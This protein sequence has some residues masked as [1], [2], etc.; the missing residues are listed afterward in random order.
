MH[1]FDGDVAILH[2]GDILESGSEY[3]YGGMTRKIVFNDLNELALLF[4]RKA[5]RK[6]ILTERS[7]EG[8]VLEKSGVLEN[9]IK[10]LAT[11]NYVECQ[12]GERVPGQNRE[13]N[14]LSKNTDILIRAY[15]LSHGNPWVK[16]RL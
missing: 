11:E 14:S 2:H 8:E 16:N 12:I 9:E 6:E 5:P 4:W 10:S 15:K 7:Y 1:N 3:T 13:P